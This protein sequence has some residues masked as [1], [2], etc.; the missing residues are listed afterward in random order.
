MASPM[1]L[2]S[3]PTEASNP[4][5][6]AGNGCKAQQPLSLPPR[7]GEEEVR[8]PRLGCFNSVRPAS[9]R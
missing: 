3:G 7:P 8:E 6:S 5:P 2:Q 9:P 1:A 4:I